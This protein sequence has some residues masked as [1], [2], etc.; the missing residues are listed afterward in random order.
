VEDHQLTY[1]TG[2]PKVTLGHGNNNEMHS[3]GGTY[4]N[5]KQTEGSECSQYKIISA[6]SA[7][8]ILH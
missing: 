5:I 6:E 1:F 3:G 8:I 4:G 2:Y 7:V